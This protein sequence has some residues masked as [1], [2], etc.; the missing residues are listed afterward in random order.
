MQ[1]TYPP[2]TRE[3][4]NE[5]SRKWSLLILKAIFLGQSR[6]NDFL[7][8]YENEGLSNKMLANELRRLE[9]FGYISKEIA[10]KTPLR[11]E[12]RLTE[13]GLGTNKIIY[14]RLKFG[15]KFGLPDLNKPAFKDVNLE[16][17]FNIE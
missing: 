17:I 7:K 3:A 13:M 4:Y 10:S 11:I 12:Y 8:F 15:M 5:L 6:F 16:K 9:Q 1:V 14:E 2:L